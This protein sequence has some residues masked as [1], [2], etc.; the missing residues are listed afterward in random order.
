MLAKVS[1]DFSPPIRKNSCRLSS[2]VNVCLHCVIANRHSVLSCRRSLTA[3][4]IEQHSCAWQRLS[5][6]YL[7]ACAVRRRRFVSL[8]DRRWC[9]LCLY[10]L[11]LDVLIST[12][13]K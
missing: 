5:Q 3:P 13:V 7:L 6:H 9:D 12:L 2:C 11:L 1:N 10:T 8:N 4:M